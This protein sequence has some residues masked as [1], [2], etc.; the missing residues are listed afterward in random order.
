MTLISIRSILVEDYQGY[1]LMVFERVLGFGS[2]TDYQNS[3]NAEKGVGTSI[4]LLT[5]ELSL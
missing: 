2:T 1:R 3:K 4:G 5:S